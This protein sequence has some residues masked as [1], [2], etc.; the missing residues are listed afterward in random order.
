MFAPLLI[1]P[2]VLA[3]DYG[4]VKCR[5]ECVAF[6]KLEHFLLVCCASFDCFVYF[7]SCVSQM[8]ALLN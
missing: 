1:G 8:S 5:S 3:Q 6:H 4:I 7:I 2:A